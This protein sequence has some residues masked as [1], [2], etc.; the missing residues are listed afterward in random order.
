MT[1]QKLA[2]DFF[3]QELA[4]RYDERNSKLSSISKNLIFLTHLVLERLPAQAKILSVGAGTG[5]EILSLAEVQPQWTFVAVEPSLSM[6]NVCRRRLQEAGVL[7]RCELVHG[8]A[9]DLPAQ[10]EFDAALAL[11]VGHFVKKEDRL[12]FYASMSD[13]LRPGG[14]LVNA[15]LSYDLESAEFPPMLKNWESIQRL[16]GAT[17]ESLAG[18]PKQL[19]NVLTV[20]PPTQVEKLI[21]ESGIPLATRFFQSFMIS[22]WFGEKAS[23]K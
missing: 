5:N 11:L 4:E 13:R 3:T 18:L 16:M 14:F 22:A 7:A 1:N 9:E 23:G 2:P 12:G 6:L 10:S 19:K 20:L 8:F 21:R 15:E 17:P